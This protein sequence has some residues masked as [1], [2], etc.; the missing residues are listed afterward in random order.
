MMADFVAVVEE[1]APEAAPIAPPPGADTAEQ[2]LR[3]YA[4]D[5]LF[6]RIS[7]AEAAEQFTAELDQSV[8]DAR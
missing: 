5:M 8:S 4:E 2:T 6:D 7:P 3:R 1:N